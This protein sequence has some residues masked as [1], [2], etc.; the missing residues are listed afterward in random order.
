MFKISLIKINNNNEKRLS[1]II[2]KVISNTFIKIAKNINF[3]KNNDIIITFIL[4]RLNF[5]LKYLRIKPF[6]FSLIIILYYL[7]FIIIIFY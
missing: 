2:K 6:Y 3:I 7:T 5:N 1:F 4:Y